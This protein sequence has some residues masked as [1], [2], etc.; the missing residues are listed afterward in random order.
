MCSIIG[1]VGAKNAAQV[2]LEGLERMEYRG[3]DSAGIAGL[4]N[5]EFILKKEVGRV[6]NLLDAIDDFSKFGNIGIG[7]T[8]WATHGGVSVKNAHPHISSSGS[9]V[10]VHN[11]VIENYEPIKKFLIKEGFTFYSE[12]DTEVLANLIEYHFRK[13]ASPENAFLSSVQRALMQVKGTYGIVVLC[14]YFPEEIVVARKSSPIIIG[15]GNV[16]RK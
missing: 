6:R 13:K 9:F 7:H 3:Y 1:Y 11:G 14:K 4:N 2:M 10:I 15:I 12:T 16:Q 5:G 8:R